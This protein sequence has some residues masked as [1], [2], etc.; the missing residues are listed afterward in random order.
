M[1]HAARLS[2]LAKLLSRIDPGGLVADELSRP[3]LAPPSESMN[4][5]M[6]ST[7]ISGP[8]KSVGDDTREY[9]LD[10]SPVAVA[11]WLIGVEVDSDM[12]VSWLVWLG[13]EA[14]ADGAVLVPSVAVATGRLGGFCAQRASPGAGGEAVASAVWSAGAVIARPAPV[15]APFDFRRARMAA[16]AVVVS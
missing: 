8:T 1:T 11:S 15:L 9:I 7:S 10:D 6:R 16:L 4:V 3:M 5:I 12:A 14:S 13:S 2:V